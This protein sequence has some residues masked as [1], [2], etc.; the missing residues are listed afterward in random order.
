MTPY[1]II[2]ASPRSAHSSSLNILPEPVAETDPAR[3]TQSSEIAIFTSPAVTLPARNHQEV[4]IV[5]I[6]DSPV[7]PAPAK[8][9]RTA[10]VLAVLGKSQQELAG[11][12]SESDDGPLSLDFLLAPRVD[13]GKRRAGSEV[14]AP[15]QAGAFSVGPARLAQISDTDAEPKLVR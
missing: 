14:A 8:P 13:K 12:G 1:A 9:T 5:D 2:D 15:V 3:P 7:R 11:S 10:E 6:A 4:I